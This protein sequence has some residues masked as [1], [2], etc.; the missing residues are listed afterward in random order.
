VAGDDDD[1]G[2]GATLAPGLPI[3]HLHGVA[4]WV[5]AA[6]AAGLLRYKHRRC[7]RLPAVQHSFP[8]GS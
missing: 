6:A 7:C 5:A 3:H 8:N 1:G 2:V 4:S